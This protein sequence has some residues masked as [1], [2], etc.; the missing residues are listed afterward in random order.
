MQNPLMGIQVDDKYKIFRL[1][2]QKMPTLFLRLT[3]RLLTKQ[4][5]KLLGFDELNQI[6]YR[7]RQFPD[8]NRFCENLLKV[9]NIEL[10]IK[11]SALEHI[12]AEGP[13]VVTSNHPFGGIDGI[14]LLACLRRRRRDVKAMVNYMLCVIPEMRDMFI[15]VDPFDR[16]ASK[17]INMRPMREC[18]TWLKEGLFL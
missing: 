15:Y 18:L 3:T 11:E 17:R 14:I 6:Y 1:N 7:T 2:P 10:E 12:P 4:L 9:M 5:E 8:D 13:V 16:Q